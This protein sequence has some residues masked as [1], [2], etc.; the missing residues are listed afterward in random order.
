MTNLPTRIIARLDIKNNHVIKGIHLEGLRKVGEPLPLATKYYKDG[1]DEIYFMDAVASLYDRNS[2]FEL[3]ELAASN[4]FIPISL[5]GG[6]R[7]IDDVLHAFN[8]GADKVII[9]T[10]A[11]KDI[12]IISKIASRFGS[13]AV[14]ASIQAKRQASDVWHAYI[15]NGREP[16][17]LNVIDW[18]QVLISEGAGEIAVTSVDQEGTRKGFDIE[19]SK[20]I[21]SISNVPVTISG[22]CGSIGHVQALIQSAAPSG[23]AIASCFH[24]ENFTPSELKAHLK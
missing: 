2:L 16:T 12:K 4:S 15:D 1:I 7:S 5:G 10:A 6:I 22:G 3:I 11:V 14:V 17:G 18:M 24:Y 23:I 21:T 9:N 20:Q 19:L 13:Q 8:S